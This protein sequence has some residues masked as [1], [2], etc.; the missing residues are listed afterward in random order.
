MNEIKGD[1]EKSAERDYKKETI[2]KLSYFSLFAF[3]TC[4]VEKRNITLLK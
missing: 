4:I 2:K 1:Y 3:H